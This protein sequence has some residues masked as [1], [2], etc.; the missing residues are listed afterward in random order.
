MRKAA[1]RRV[2]KGANSPLTLVKIDLHD[3]EF[4]Y[5][6]DAPLFRIPS[7]SIASGEAVGVFGPSGAGKTSLLKLL[8]GICLPTKGRID[9]GGT[10]L[11]DLS[12]ADR[13][14]FRN[15]RVGLVFQDFRLLEYLSV[16]ENILL[17]FRI[18]AGRSPTAA[19][20]ARADELVNRLELRDRVSASPRALSQGEQQRAAIGRALIASPQVILADEPTGNLDQR[21]KGRIRDLLLE[22]SRKH[23]VTLVMVT[24]DLALLDDFERVLDF[25]EFETGGKV[26]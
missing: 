23:K 20:R 25:S 7:F 1:L 5:R 15:E 26:A 13:R 11:N 21:N 18:G 14:Q 4:G 24:H 8:A 10:S 6:S 9:I 19:D 2:A 3:I 16:K 22:H 17:P 12:D